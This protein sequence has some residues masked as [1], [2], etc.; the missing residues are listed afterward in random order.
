MNIRIPTYRHTFSG[1]V[2]ASLSE[3]SRIHR[4]D[5]LADFKKHWH[6]FVHDND[7]LI[8]TEKTR[9]IQN[10]FKGNITDTLFKSARFYYRK[11]HLNS[12]INNK[13]HSNKKMYMCL[14]P[15]F[16]C[17]ID[18]HIELAIS[19]NLH[20]TDK[21]NIISKT[22]P[23]KSYTDFCVKHTNDIHTEVNSFISLIKYHNMSISC[24]DICLKFKKTYKNRFY[25]I[26]RKLC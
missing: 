7:T 18:K 8:S 17:L 15:E 26:Q 11:L 22:T 24:E 3:F 25:V 6:T 4:N 1:D 14:S 20:Y 9:L 23:A 16:L 5:D 2:I 13:S 21:Y 12:H 19:S 10:G